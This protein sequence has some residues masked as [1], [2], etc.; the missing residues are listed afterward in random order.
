MAARQQL[1]R[2]ERERLARRKDIMQAARSVFAK[3]GYKNATLEQIARRA[4]FAKGTFYNYFESKS[5][6]FQEILVSLL[7]QMAVVARQTMNEG[8]TTREK[9]H[10]YSV[11]IINLF[12]EEEDFLKI[13]MREMN[14]M[15]LEDQ[16]EKLAFFRKKFHRMKDIL[17]ESLKA[18]IAKGRIVNEK[19]EELAHL[20]M[21]MI[22]IRSARCSRDE[23]SLECLD[24]EKESAFIVKLFFDGASTR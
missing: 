18:D 4:E 15:M 11:R 24:A 7:D 2:K 13:V 16:H 14:R 6:I 20:F 1:Q 23:G 17:A 5:D 3:H 22:H 9:F 12:K 19:P 10:R 8:G 21:E